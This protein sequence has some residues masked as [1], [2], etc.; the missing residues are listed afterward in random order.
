MPQL[1][2]SYRIIV[3]SSP[4]HLFLCQ[5]FVS[6]LLYCNIQGIYK[7]NKHLEQRNKYNKKGAKDKYGTYITYMLTKHTLFP[8]RC[9]APS[10]RTYLHC[11]GSTTPSTP[12]KQQK[13]LKN[14]T[15]HNQPQPTTTATQLTPATPTTT[16]CH[17]HVVDDSISLSPTSYTVISRPSKRYL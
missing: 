4:L 1:Y 3:T 12:A 8:S 7:F 15:N 16:M 13:L 5:L 11:P 6:L 9:P 14:Y 2:N 17:V 10:K